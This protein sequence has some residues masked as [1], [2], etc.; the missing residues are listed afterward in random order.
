MP[1][2]DAYLRDSRAQ[3]I[4]KN[5]CAKLDSI[6]TESIWFM[7]QLTLK[8]CIEF[9][10]NAMILFLDPIDGLDTDTSYPIYLYS[11][12]CAGGG[13]EDWDP[14]WF[15]GLPPPPVLGDTGT[16]WLFRFNMIFWGGSPLLLVCSVLLLLL[17]LTLLG[18]W[19]LLAFE[20][21][22]AAACLSGHFFSW[23]SLL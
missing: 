21:S 10:F 14:E 9:C 15:D 20:R 13:A 2:F 22:W 16:A 5:V 4:S 11:A 6:F 18:V 7:L 19:V 8:I 12:V 3:I 1:N 17:L 23:P